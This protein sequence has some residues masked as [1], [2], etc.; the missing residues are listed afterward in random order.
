MRKIKCGTTIACTLKV[1]RRIYTQTVPLSLARYCSSNVNQIVLGLS[2]TSL[3]GRSWLVEVDGVP[4]GVLVVDMSGSIIV[5]QGG[6]RLGGEEEE[7]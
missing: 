6:G 2:T 5:A 7:T 3:G 1:K 4:G